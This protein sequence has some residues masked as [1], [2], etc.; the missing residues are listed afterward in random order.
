M[1]SYTEDPKGSEGV[2]LTMLNL[3]TC[4]GWPNSLC[5]TLFKLSVNIKKLLLEMDSPYHKGIFKIVTVEGT[6][7]GSHSQAL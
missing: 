3:P 1:A 4:L 5:H 7:F 6:L 2:K